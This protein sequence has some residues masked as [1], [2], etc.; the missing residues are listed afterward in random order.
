M[1]GYWSASQSIFFEESLPGKAFPKRCTQMQ[2][3]GI[4][5]AH[6]AVLPGTFI[7]KVEPEL[8]LRLPKEC[9]PKKSM[10]LSMFFQFSAGKPEKIAELFWISWHFLRRLWDDFHEVIHIVSAQPRNENGIL[11]CS[12]KNICRYI[13]AL[14]RS[15]KIEAGDSFSVM[16]WYV[17]YIYIKVYLYVYIYMIYLD[18]L[19]SS[20]MIF[21][22]HNWCNWW[23]SLEN[24]GSS[25]HKA[26]P[27]NVYSNSRLPPRTNI[28][29]REQL[30]TNG[31][32]RQEQNTDGWLQAPSWRLQLSIFPHRPTPLVFGWSKSHLMRRE[33]KAEE[34]GRL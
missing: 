22:G 3:V 9:F 1:P 17:Y 25:R 21:Y 29:K 30:D 32:L 8:Q 10:N 4:M 12:T 34:N 13:L 20:S 2:N 27:R 14:G 28:D 31:S 19:S 5:C 23:A 6:L 7:H 16:S 24:G 11:H 26:S 15:W 18:I 33:F